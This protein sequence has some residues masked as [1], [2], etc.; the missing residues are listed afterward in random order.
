[1]A[2]SPRSFPTSWPAVSTRVSSSAT[3]FASTSGETSGRR[4]PF[5][6]IESVGNMNALWRRWPVRGPRQG[7]VT[8]H[9]RTLEPVG[10]AL[11]QAEELGM[12]PLAARCHLG[13]GALYSEADN[14]RQAKKH[15]TAATTLFRDM[16]MQSWSMRAARLLDQRRPPSS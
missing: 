3:T 12:R 11:A 1:M 15:L 6:A 7:D 9:Y 2:T 4:L 10:T 13:L 8:G 5:D 14:Y 16:G